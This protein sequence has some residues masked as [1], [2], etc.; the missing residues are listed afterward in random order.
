VLSQLSEVE[1]MEL[2]V[3]KMSKTK[4]NSQFLDAMSKG[5]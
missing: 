3:E 1:A 5:L 2:L 4:T